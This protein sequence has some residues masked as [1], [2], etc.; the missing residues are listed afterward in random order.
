MV[1]QAQNRQRI[2]DDSIMQGTGQ[3]LCYLNQKRERCFCGERKQIR[4]KYC[5]DCQL[6]ITRQSKVKWNEK[7]R[8][9]QRLDKFYKN[10]RIN[11]IQSPYLSERR[12]VEPL[13]NR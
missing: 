13:R 10:I 1:A 8:K 3:E 12:I 5:I 4:K 6:K 2:K 7:L 11:L 9:K